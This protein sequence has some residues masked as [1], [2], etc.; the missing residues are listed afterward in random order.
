MFVENK[1]KIGTCP[2]ALWKSKINEYKFT[3]ACVFFVH[4]IFNEYFDN[5]GTIYIHLNENTEFNRRGCC[6]CVKE[7]ICCEV[8]VDEI[9]FLRAY[10]DNIIKSIFSCLLHELGH[11]YEI[12]SKYDKEKYKTL[13]EYFDII[14]NIARKIY[15]DNKTISEM[16]ISRLIPDEILAD[17]FA[18]KNL[19]YFEN[20]YKSD[21]ILV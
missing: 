13:E 2:E 14:D 4:D 16:E 6:C 19:S 20:L 17:R 8:Y 7:D 21:D 12:V 10:P 9:L 11:A 1:I 18:Y 15:E 3:S 5:F